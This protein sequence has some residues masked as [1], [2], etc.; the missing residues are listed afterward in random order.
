MPVYGQTLTSL[1]ENMYL[2]QANVSMAPENFHPDGQPKTEIELWEVRLVCA[3]SADT[4]RCACYE[5][6]GAKV[7]IQ[8]QR[9]EELAQRGS[10]L[11]Q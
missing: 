8:Q 3:Y 11:Q 5:P 9:C 4:G 7:R 2:G 6:A 1:T 10:I